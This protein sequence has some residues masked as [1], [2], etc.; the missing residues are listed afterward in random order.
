MHTV[1]KPLKIQQHTHVSPVTGQKNQSHIHVD[2]Q[3]HSTRGDGRRFSDLCVVF[4]N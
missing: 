3:E 1:V 4:L 2:N